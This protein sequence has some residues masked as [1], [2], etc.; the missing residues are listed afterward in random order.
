[1]NMSRTGDTKAEALREEYLLRINRVIDY[2][3]AHLDSD[4]SL[5]TLVGSEAYEG[6]WNTVYGEWLPQSGY[7]TDGRPCFE[8]Y[9]NN[10]KEHSQGVHIVDICVP[11]KP[12]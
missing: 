8:I 7:Q 10:P 2:I 12:L 1:M 3:E 5:E 4:L 6:A 11:V 9:H